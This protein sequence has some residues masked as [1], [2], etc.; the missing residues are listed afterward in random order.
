MVT[1]G[2]QSSRE[3]LLGAEDGRAAGTIA[4]PSMTYESVTRFELP[5]GAHQPLRLRLQAAAPGVLTITVYAG[6][7]LESPGEV[8][9]SM[10]RSLEPADVSDGR[11]G[12]W[13]VEGL[14]NMKRLEG[15][16]WIGVRKAGGQPALWASGASSVQAFLRND[17]PHNP[18]DLLPT[19]RAPMLRLEIA[20]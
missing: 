4:F 6:T 19:K 11:D 10:T 18:I 3:L 9:L 20:P 1:A 16:V 13:V 17:D 15:V 12:R 7:P 5:S 8:I 2:G 14:D